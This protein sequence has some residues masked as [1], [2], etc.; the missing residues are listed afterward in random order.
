MKNLFV[1][2]SQLHLFLACG[3][4]QGRFCNDENHVILFVDFNITKELEQILEQVFDKILYRIGT[5]PAINKTW[6]EKLKRYPDDLKE[7]RL[8]MNTPYDRVFEACDDCIPELYILKYT[9]KNN[10]EIEF[11]WLEEGAYFRN[12]IDVSGFSSNA[13]TRNIRKILFKYL[14]GLGRF[15]NFDGIHAGSN[16]I[17]KKAYLTFPGKQRSIYNSKEIIGITDEEFS[18]G[19]SALYPAREENRLKDGSILLVMD[20]LDVYKDICKVQSAI[21]ELVFNVQKRGYTIYYKYHPR[22]ESQLEELNSCIELPRNTGVENL[23]SASK[24]NDIIVIGIKS[25]G[26]QNAKKLGFC[27]IS[28]ANVVDEGDVDVLSFYDKIGI[29]I[30][31][32]IK[33]ITI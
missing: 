13:F 11:S 6:K 7:I 5:Y 17:L 8:F 1:C 31:D 29:E 21:S 30:V 2:H 3:L 9:Y 10:K 24:G 20:K 16:H 25:T 27:V 12:T 18:L 15:Y 4:V 22:E 33:D 32:T 28:I 19:L 23:Y 14:L 26:L